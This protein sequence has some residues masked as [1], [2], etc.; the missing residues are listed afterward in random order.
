MVGSHKSL[1]WGAEVVAV[2]VPLIKIGDI[3][4]DSAGD[5]QEF[6]GSGVL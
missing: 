3:P 5:G 1:R 2:A 6:I 4:I